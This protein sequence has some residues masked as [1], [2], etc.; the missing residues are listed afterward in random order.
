M[1]TRT[2]RDSTML[3]VDIRAHL[4]VGLGGGKR[5]HISMVRVV[6]LAMG[7]V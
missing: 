2:R 6:A 3:G 1:I 4:Q 5:S 7:G